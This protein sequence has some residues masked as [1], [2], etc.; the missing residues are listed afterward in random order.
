M[1]FSKEKNK[2]FGYSR[3]SGM[4]NYVIQTYDLREIVISGGA[5][6]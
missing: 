2:N 3:I 5:Y 4:F 6:T 1:R